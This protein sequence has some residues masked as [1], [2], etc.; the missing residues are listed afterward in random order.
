[1]KVAIV[2]PWFLE[3][4]GG[5]KVV[6]A[7]AEM[8]P[9]ADIFTLAADP[10]VVST[11]L[12]GRR[13][14]TSPLN[15]LLVSRFRYKRINFSPLF[16]W[17][18]ER[19]DLSDY[20]LVISSCGP[21]VMGVNVSP[22]SLHVVYCHTPQRAWW[23][24]YAARQATMSAITKNVFVASSVF[25]RN[26]EFAAMQRVDQ[27]ISNSKYV[28]RRV[29]RY[30]CRNST[31]VHPPVNTSMGYLSHRPGNYYLALSRLDIDKRLD[32]AILACN[33]LGR[34]LLVAGSGR[35][36]KQLKSIAGPTIEFLGYVPDSACPDL[37]A[38]CRALIFPADEDFGI[39]PVEAQAFGRPV[40]A[41]GHGGS[42]ETVRVGDPDDRRNTGV[43]FYEQTVE[44]VTSAIERFERIEANLNPVEI[45]RHA[46]KFD[47]SVFRAEM[48]R[49]IRLC[50]HNSDREHYEPRAV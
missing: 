27:V 8:Y 35:S 3:A 21:A 12:Q 49:V 14:H 43:F 33:K 11:R 32:L 23:D 15:R 44:A 31:V 24:L 50:H 10:R 25:I 19:M 41:Y 16:P 37:F 7:L 17:A 29:S 48:S 45:Q 2:H 26:W 4:G 46:R 18:V 42:L 22:D 9:E 28:A 5:E 40:I 39:V 38:N 30:F 34:R 36:E 13:I 20:E 1:M 47:E 6:E